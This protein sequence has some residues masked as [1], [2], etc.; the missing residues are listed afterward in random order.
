MLSID[1]IKV[2]YVDMKSAC[3]AKR[4]ALFVTYAIDLS[5][6]HVA[7]QQCDFYSS[8]GDTVMCKQY[9]I[10]VKDKRLAFSTELKKVD[11][12]LR[13]LYYAQD[14]DV[15]MNDHYNALAVLFAG[16]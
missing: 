8:I 2:E 14:N 4:L 12:I 7:E 16:L 13:G 1:E 10:I 3:D 5:L 15:Y 11:K 6:A 9:D